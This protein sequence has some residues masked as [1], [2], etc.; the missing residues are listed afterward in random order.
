MP[1]DEL[2]HVVPI[3]VNVIRNKVRTVLIKCP[4]CLKT[5][6]HGW[7]LGDTEP[8]GTRIAH[9]GLG[10]GDQ[11]FIELPPVVEVNE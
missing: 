7:A 2:V 6:T 10:R 1:T 4:F 8:P 9:C 5:H 11:Y 3:G